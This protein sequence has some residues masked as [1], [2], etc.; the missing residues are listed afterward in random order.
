MIYPVNVAAL[1]AVGGVDAGAD[2]AVADVVARSQGGFHV[3]AVVGIH[4]HGVVRAGSLGGGDEPGDHIVAVGAA[5]ILGAD[6]DLAL[7]AA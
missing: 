7:G 4:I 5:G 6:A 3:G 1:V 2:E